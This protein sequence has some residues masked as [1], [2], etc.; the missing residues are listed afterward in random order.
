MTLRLPEEKLLAL[1]EELLDS[2]NRNR[3]TKRQL[4]S[5]AGRLSWAAS[6]VK[7]G[8]VHR[9]IINT[10]RMLRDIAHRV[11][12]MPEGPEEPTLMVQFHKHL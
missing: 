5:L 10:I 6:V 3:F 11:R 4:Q 2:L 9:R 8:P 1:K 12:L 7:G